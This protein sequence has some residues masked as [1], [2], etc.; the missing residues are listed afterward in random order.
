MSEI[1]AV[2]EKKR[3]ETRLR[4]SVRG[5]RLI[6]KQ[7]YGLLMKRMIDTWRRKILYLSMMII[8]LCM[9]IFVVLSLNP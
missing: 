8:P 2:N 7:M 6:M 9:T 4:K 5:L 3:S 1:D